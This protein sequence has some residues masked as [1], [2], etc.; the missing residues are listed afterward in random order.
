MSS[1]K[2]HRDAIG[3]RP[4]RDFDFQKSVNP[5][6]LPPQEWNL[7]FQGHAP[8]KRQPDPANQVG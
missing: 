7:R 3:G 6:Q 2:G 4:S 8:P 1:T 5:G